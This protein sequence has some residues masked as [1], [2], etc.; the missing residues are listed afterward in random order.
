MLENLAYVY[1]SIEDPIRSLSTSIQL[2]DMLT[3]SEERDDPKWKVSYDMATQYCAEA[4]VLLGR[5]NEALDLFAQENVEKKG[6]KY[7][8]GKLSADVSTTV[9]N[10]HISLGNIDVAEEC[11]QQAISTGGCTPGRL[12]ILL[13]IYLTR[14]DY[15]SALELI[16]KQQVPTT[17]W[18]KGRKKKK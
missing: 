12:W 7:S 18:D 3:S 14:R 9:A 17:R 1:L 11:V 4:I 2:L 5:S 10:V 6:K 8:K 13:Y 15:I 16:R